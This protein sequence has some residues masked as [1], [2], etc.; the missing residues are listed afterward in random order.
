MVDTQVRP[1]DVTK[2]PII[3]AML[4]VPREAFVP[5]SQAPIAYADGPIPLGGGREMT[6]PRTLAKMLDALDVEADEDV[7]VVA[8]GTGY[9][10]ALL[11]RMAGS[12][13]AVDADADLV[14]EAEAALAGLGIDVAVVQGDPAEGLAKAGPYDV[15][16]IDGAVE[17]VPD[18]LTDQL[19]DGGRIGAIFQ[20]GMVGEA[21]IGVRAEGAIGWRVAFNAGGPVLP[22]F[23]RA[24]SFAL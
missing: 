8:A 19:R 11:W 16:L 24:R 3:A 18:A 1:S 20:D 14:S 9:A 2:F 17:R 6:E 13:V 10:A 12:V 21:R 15:I 4:D 5:S 23:E 7:L 22:G